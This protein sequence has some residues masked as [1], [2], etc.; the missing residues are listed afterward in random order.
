MA[1]TE[2]EYNAKFLVINNYINENF[3]SIP[4]VES[5]SIF[6]TSGEPW[7]LGKGM[8]YGIQYVTAK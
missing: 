7:D 3:L 5:D 6:V 8:H 4:L 2:E 1:K